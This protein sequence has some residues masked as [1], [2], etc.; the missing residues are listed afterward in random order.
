MRNDEIMRLMRKIQIRIKGGVDASLKENDMT[1]SQSFVMAFIDKHGGKVSQKEIQKHLNVS[2]PTVVGLIK[3]LENNGFVYCEVDEN[4][5]RNKMVFNTDKA[6]KLRQE[7]DKKRDAFDTKMMKG[8]SDQECDEL[9]TLLT[10]LY[11]NISEEQES[12][13]E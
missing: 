5:K 6:T 10:K 1:F 4:D 13:E 2:H 7:M 8:F 9:V 11:D 3:R 12:D